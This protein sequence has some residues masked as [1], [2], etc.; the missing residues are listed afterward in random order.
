MTKP[1]LASTKATRLGKAEKKAPKDGSQR[2]KIRHHTM[3]DCPRPIQRVDTGLLLSSKA[4]FV[5]EI[6]SGGEMCGQIDNEFNVARVDSLFHSFPASF[7]LGHGL[8]SFRKMA[9]I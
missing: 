9:S 7:T 5:M 8:F 1:K 4:A 2:D 6:P 3:A